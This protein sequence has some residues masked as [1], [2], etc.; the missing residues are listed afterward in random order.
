MSIRT[1]Q[2]HLVFANDLRAGVAAVARAIG[3]R[4]AKDFLYIAEN[5]DIRNNSSISNQNAHI[6][7]AGYCATAILAIC[8]SASMLGIEMEPIAELVRGFDDQPLPDWI[9]SRDG[10]VSSGP[11]HAWLST[12][13]E[14][15]LGMHLVIEYTPEEKIAVRRLFAAIHIGLCGPLPVGNWGAGRHEIVGCPECITNHKEH[16]GSCLPGELA[17]AARDGEIDPKYT[18]PVFPQEWNFGQPWIDSRR[19]GVRLTWKVPSAQCAVDVQYELNRLGFKAE[20][21]PG[22]SVVTAQKELERGDIHDAMK[23]AFARFPK[24]IA[25]YGA[26][27]VFS[28]DNPA[29]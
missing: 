12:L 28:L 24:D 11:E 13:A 17:M 3:V 6:F 15:S 8:N 9:S 27:T 7:P 29:F 14:L 18:P 21:N 2:T 23:W 10:Q 16:G 4:Q 19:R 26:E 1:S 5:E 20:I 25:W 22:W